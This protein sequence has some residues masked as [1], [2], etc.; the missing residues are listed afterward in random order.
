MNCEI[1]RT[2]NLYRKEFIFILFLTGLNC[3]LRFYKLAAQGLW[4]S[5]EVVYY[6]ACHD[7]INSFHKSFSSSQ[8]MLKGLFSTLQ[9]LTQF[10]PKFGFYLVNSI[11]WDIFDYPSTTLFV[12]AIFS[13]L[14]IVVVFI[15]GRRFFNFRVGI[16]A[17]ILFSFSLMYL[18]WSRTGFAYA[19]TYFWLVLGF[20]YYLNNL[21]TYAQRDMILTGLFL[22]IATLFHPQ[23]IQFVLILAYAEIIKLFFM[24]RKFS[25]FIKR[26]CIMALSFLLPFF[27]LEVLIY[28]G[29]GA[30]W[31]TAQNYFYQIYNITSA[32]IASRQGLSVYPYFYLLVLWVLESPLIFLL[33]CLSFVCFLKKVKRCLAEECFYPQLLIGL[34]FILP[35]GYWVLQNKL[36]Q[37]DYNLLGAWPFLFLFVALGLEEFFKK[38][39]ME[40]SMS[41]LL[42]VL[43]ILGILS[44]SFY[45]LRTFY[46]IK[47][48]FPEVSKRLKELKIDKIIVYR[49]GGLWTYRQIDPYL[50]D[51]EFFNAD[52][53]EEVYRIAKKENVEYCFYGSGEFAHARIRDAVVDG[54]VVAK[55][56]DTTMRPHYPLL[57][58]GL[59][60]SR[61]FPHTE[62]V[63]KKYMKD[64]AFDYMYLYRLGNRQ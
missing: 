54:T 63:Y 9:L 41:I 32:N 7:I 24:E 56:E 59:I 28:I 31:Y 33:C 64:E 27:I 53:N 34:L 20:Y 58:Y 29:K 52:T 10:P 40:G 3:F 49:Y 35:Y 61:I 62:E 39:K 16:V 30:G 26:A 4:H 19:P 13:I 44:Y 46:R 11:G 6:M 38:I 22:A 1:K 37:V 43:V 51:V 21:K 8:D 25:F 57:Y 2:F 42:V 5:D 60:S 48:H 12:S 17:S 23:I 36:H 15:I 45:H 50:K 47:S 18:R 55:I 14:T